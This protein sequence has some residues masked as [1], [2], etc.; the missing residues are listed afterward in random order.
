MT[1]SLWGKGK[2]EGEENPEKKG[3]VRESRTEGD[4]LSNSRL[5]KPPNCSPELQPC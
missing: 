1:I 3:G 2:K 4:L 5:K